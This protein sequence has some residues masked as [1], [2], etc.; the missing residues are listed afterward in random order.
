[1]FKCQFQK[2]EQYVT[3][4][5]RQQLSS[6]QTINTP[7]NSITNAISKSTIKGTVTKDIQV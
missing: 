7:V 4:N 5:A 1:M 6:K 3:E 2:E